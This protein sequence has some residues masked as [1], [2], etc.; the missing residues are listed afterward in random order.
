MHSCSV[1]YIM[2]SDYQYIYCFQTEEFKSLVG[3]EHIDWVAQ[4]LVMK[5]A[6]I[7]P[8]FHN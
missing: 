3:D 7:E 1:R 5:R 2:Y 4:Y 8:N 6:S